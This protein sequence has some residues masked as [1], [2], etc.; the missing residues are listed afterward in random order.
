MQVVRDGSDAAMVTAPELSKARRLHVELPDEAGLL[1][2][3]FKS[4]PTR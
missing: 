4:T 1:T 3:W 2:Y